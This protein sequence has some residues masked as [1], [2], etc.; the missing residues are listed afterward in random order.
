MTSSIRS[1]LPGRGSPS[2]GHR[3]GDP[4]E[5]FA[6]RVTLLFIGLIVLV[7][8]IVVFAFAY[9]Y[10][11]GH[12]K[13]VATVG[14][15][16]ISRDQWTAR[17]R[18]EYYRL[19]NQEQ[20][21]REQI[22]A[23]TLT[24]DEGNLR[25]QN[26]ASARNNVASS[27]IENLIDLTFQ[28]QLAQAA[29]LS[30]TDA[31]VDEAIRRESTDP[32]ARQ[33]SVIFVEPDAITGTPEE[34]QAAFTAAQDAAAALEAGTPFADV[35]REF[36]T[37][38]SAD[39]GGEYG[40]VT[41]DSTLDAAFIGTM[42]ALEEGQTSPVIK[43]ADGVWRI[44]RV[45]T[46]RPGGMDPGL[47]QV[48]RDEVGWDL[49]RSNVRKEALAQKLEDQVVADATAGDVPQAHVAEIFLEGDTVAAP[50][51]DE[52]RIRASHILYS[53]NDDP[54]AAATLDPEDPAWAAAQA[55]ADTAAAQ[56]RKVTDPEL[57]ASAFAARSR[58]QSDDT[59]SGA[60]GGDLGY[61]S[62]EMM[63]PEFADP[64]FDDPELVTG[65]IVGPVRSDFGWHVIQFTDRTPSLQERIDAVVAGLAEEDA[66]FAAVATELS[67][68]AEA[69]AGGDLGWLTDAQLE[70]EAWSAVVALEPAAHTEAIPLDDGYHFFQLIEQA[71]RPLDIQQRAVVEDTA[72][73]AWYGP[74]EEQAIVDGVITRDEDL[75]SS[76]P[77]I[78]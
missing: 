2:R 74:Q 54:S 27:A 68:G 51:E 3:A 1:R 75:F 58:S 24:P 22:S 78:E 30:V 57:R 44:G 14:G 56:L 38:D 37:D 64:L 4:E 71:D 47:E 62:R 34:R 48:M 17:A 20:N 41:S 69:P 35:A 61:F 5:R 40:F 76:A 8:A 43:G 72:F 9:D 16:S 50:S 7:V 53:P 52:G 36:S 73:A 66:D 32:E 21:T 39:R 31:D 70:E 29:G 60:E 18:L 12:L 13:P 59:T 26:L 25:L 6:Q 15:E 46:I 63:V 19:V 11:I 55:E 28:G 23:G 65:D 42:F 77:V 49:Y 33:I 10:Y 45:D 67:D